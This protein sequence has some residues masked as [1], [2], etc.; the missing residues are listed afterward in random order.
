MAETD[1]GVAGGGLD[2]GA[3]G[4]QGAAALGVFHHGQR[5]AVLDGAARVG[6]FGL[7]PDFAA[8]EQ[9][10]HANVR[11]LANRFEDVLGFHEALSVERGVTKVVQIRGTYTMCPL[12]SE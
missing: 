4:L 1:A 8:W 5:N 12:R 3:A 2:D 6:A 11:G 10:A 9:A 7:D